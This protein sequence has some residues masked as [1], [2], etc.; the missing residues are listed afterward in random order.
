M[1]DDIPWDRALGTP[2][3]EKRK[4]EAKLQTSRLSRHAVTAVTVL[5][6]PCCLVLFLPPFQNTAFLPYNALR[7]PLMER[8]L[9]CLQYRLPYGGA[10]RGGRAGANYLRDPMMRTSSTHCNPRAAS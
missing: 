7:L 8:R 10:C 9:P 4:K 6:S 2:L 5:A 3:P 1:A